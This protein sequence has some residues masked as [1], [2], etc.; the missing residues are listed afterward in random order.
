MSLTA[1]ELEHQQ[2]REVVEKGAVQYEGYQ[3]S[4]SALSRWRRRFGP[5]G[6]HLT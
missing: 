5:V 3:R 4:Q 6:I 2:D 1:V